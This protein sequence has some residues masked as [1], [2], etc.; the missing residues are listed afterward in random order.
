MRPPSSRSPPRPDHSALTSDTRSAEIA[1]YPNARFPGVVVWSEI[2]QASSAADPPFL[3]RG[4]GVRSEQSRLTCKQAQVTGPVLRFANSIA[5]Q[6]YICAVPCC[7]HEFAGADAIPYDAEGTDAGNSYKIKKLLSATDEDI[8]KAIDVL[9]Q[10]PN[11]TGPPCYRALSTCR[12]SK[13]STSLD[14][15]YWRDG[16]VLRWP[17]GG[18]SA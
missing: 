5:S 16:H 1:G 10:H 7:F 14:R 11:C 4:R 9:V 12:H 8:Q 6:G 15:A 3:Q 17:L 18:T 2:Y 13:L